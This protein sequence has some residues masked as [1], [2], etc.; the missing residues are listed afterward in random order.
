LRVLL[1]GAISPIK[2]IEQ[3]RLHCFWDADALI[4]NDHRCRFSLFAKSLS[5]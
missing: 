1:V 3:V 5:E 4:G 2:A